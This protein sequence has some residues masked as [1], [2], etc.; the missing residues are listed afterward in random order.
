MD[1]LGR[2]I[3]GI[4][5]NMRQGATLLEALTKVFFMLYYRKRI[6]KQAEEEQRLLRGSKL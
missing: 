2:R 4:N 1:Q 3:C 5:G 6:V